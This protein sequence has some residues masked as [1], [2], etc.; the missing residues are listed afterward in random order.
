MPSIFNPLAACASL[1]LPPAPLTESWNPVVVYEWQPM[2]CGSVS[3]SK[4][5][6]FGYKDYGALATIGRKIA[7]ADF[8][9]IRLRGFVGWLTWSLAHIYFLI[10]FRNRFSVALDWT[11]SYLTFQRGARLITGPVEEAAKPARQDGEAAGRKAA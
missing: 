11:W 4:R 9:K 8:G 6:A 3:S 7:I 10:G 1:K 5:F 2:I